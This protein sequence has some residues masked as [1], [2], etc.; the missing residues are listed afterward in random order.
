MDREHS[1]EIEQKTAEALLAQAEKLE[2]AIARDIVFD[3]EGHVEARREFHYLT[4]VKCAL[5]RRARETSGTR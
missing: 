1:I 4:C 5:E 3:A 2:H